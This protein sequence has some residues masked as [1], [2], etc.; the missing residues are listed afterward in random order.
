MQEDTTTPHEPLEAPQSAPSWGPY[1]VG[2]ALVLCFAQYL[3]WMLDRWWRDEYYGHGLLIPLICG[4]IVYRQLPVYKSLPRERQAAGLWVMVLGLVLHL[5]ATWKDVNFASGFAFLITLYGAVI[6]LWGWPVA[7]AAAF[8]VAFMAFGVPMGRVLVDMF[9]QP[10][11]LFSA[12]LGGGFSQAIG[13][14]T[15]IEG[16]KIR[17]PEY[18]FEVAVACSGLKTIISMSALGAL[19]AWLVEAAL[20][21]RVVLFLAS[22]PV[23]VLANAARIATTLVLGHIF[24]QKAAEGFF[25]T[26]SGVIV[27]MYALIGLFAVGG[28]LRCTRMREDI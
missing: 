13:V 15:K 2:A 18:T 14:P 6:W 8:P 11:Q 16:T 20:Y 23:A 3:G 5:L 19:Y 10:M 28:L 25:H 7:R 26:A 17:L 21:K 9:A 22:F 12:Q 27:F 4:Y 24:G 1:V